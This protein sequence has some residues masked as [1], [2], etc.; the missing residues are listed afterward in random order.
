VGLKGGPLS[1]PLLFCCTTEELLESKV[2]APV[3]KTENTA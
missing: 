3:A 2:A 1:D